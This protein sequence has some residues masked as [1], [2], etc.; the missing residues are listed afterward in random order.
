MSTPINN[1]E[2]AEFEKRA[3]EFDEKLKYQTE[4]FKIALMPVP[5]ILPDGRIGAMLRLADATK[6]V[7]QKKEAEKKQESGIIEG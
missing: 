3:K 1:Y 2:Q 6:L 7:E 4:K 5:V